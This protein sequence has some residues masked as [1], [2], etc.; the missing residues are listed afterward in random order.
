LSYLITIFSK[1]LNSFSQKIGDIVMQDGGINE[2]EL[3]GV[4]RKHLEEYGSLLNVNTNYLVI[5][6]SKFKEDTYTISP[7]NN[8]AFEDKVKFIEEVFPN[9]KNT[10]LFFDNGQRIITLCC[11]SEKLDII[12]PLIYNY[13]DKLVAYNIKDNDSI[14]DLARELLIFVKSNSIGIVHSEFCREASIKS[15]LIT[16]I[17]WINKVPIEQN[18]ELIEKIGKESYGFDRNITTLLLLVKWMVFENIVVFFY[19]TP[20]SGESG[21]GGIVWGIDFQNEPKLDLLWSIESYAALLCSFIDKILQAQHQ[22]RAI[23][24]AK[25]AANISIL[26]DSFAHNVAAHSLTAL[27]N[28]FAKRKNELEKKD[29][30]EDLE[31]Y[32]SRK[33]IAC[34]IRN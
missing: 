8:Q 13:R 1:Q 5:K 23:Q 30:S 4:F 18:I 10:E 20:N 17:E 29:I 26:V 25:R 31:Y 34:K 2:K 28:Y 19:P 14:Y 33:N 9:I 12:E 21:Q 15:K 11:T 3:S 24:S 22:K 6:L 32:A 16:D 27:S 7:N